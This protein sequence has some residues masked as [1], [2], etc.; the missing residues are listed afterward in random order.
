MPKKNDTENFVKNHPHVVARQMPNNYEAEVALLGGMLIDGQ[1]AS[2]YMPQLGADSFYTPSHKY[3]Y[4][5]MSKL[6]VA[7]N[8]IDFVTTVGALESA[9]TLELAGGTEYLSKIINAVPTVANIGYYFDIV[10]KTEQLR[11]LIS[12]AQKMADTAYALDPE[13]SALTEA[14]AAL[15]SLAEST[16]R[17]KPERIDKFAMEVLDDLRKRS[18]DKNISHGVPTGFIFLDQKLGGGFQNSDLIILA[19]RPGQGKT[20]FA[21]NCAVNAAL[22]KNTKT[23]NPF[24]VAVFSLEMSATQ[25]A[26]RIL[27]SVANFDMSRANRALLDSMEWGRM[28]DAREKLSHTNLFI[29]ESGNITPAEILSKCRALKRSSSG[30]DFVMID[31]LQLMQSGKRV[32]NFVREIAE[33]TRAIKLAAKE[34]D[35]PILLLSQMSRSIEQRKNND[36]ESRLSDLRDSGAIEQDADVV[37]FID[38]KEVPGSPSD[39]YLNIA[40]H[41]NGE[42]GNIKLLWH[43]STTTFTTPNDKGESDPP[44]EHKAF[45]GDDEDDGEDG[46]GGGHI[47]EPPPE[48]GRGARGSAA[49]QG[50]GDTRGESADSSPSTDDIAKAD[51]IF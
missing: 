48:A 35:V 13:N 2:T 24:S 5:G 1:V 46:A 26:K 20:S 43:P 10:K 50:A 31:Y 22:R 9:G 23:G 33:I 28:F 38:R 16:T 32:D 39:V 15:Y 25:L 19:A 34:L 6:F 41:R 14:E 51:E 27:C 8:A 36:K 40:K 4:D 11:A 3:I 42:T 30:L 45:S 21:M 17:G 7:A 37:L 47:P 44:G 12:I 18:A 49:S 29:D